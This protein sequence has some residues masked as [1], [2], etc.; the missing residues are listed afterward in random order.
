MDNTIDKL[1]AMIRAHMEAD[2]GSTTLRDAKHWL[3]EQGFNV[4]EVNEAVHRLVTTL[5][6]GNGVTRAREYCQAP[7]QYSPFEEAKLSQGI[8]GTIT[9][10]ETSEMISGMERELLIE[11]LLQTDSESEMELLDY[12]LTTVIGVRRNVESQNTLMNTFEGFGP[13]YH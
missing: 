8:R 7:R 9:R 1:V 4:D 2:P 3:L 5:L 6:I 12:M 13:T 11:R 10:L